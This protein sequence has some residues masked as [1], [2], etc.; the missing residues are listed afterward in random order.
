MPFWLEALLPCCLAAPS[1]LLCCQL[2]RLYLW[3]PPASQARPVAT[4]LLLQ[5]PTAHCY[6]S[7]AVLL[8]LS[9]RSDSQFVSF[10]PKR[11]VNLR[12]VSFTVHPPVPELCCVMLC[13]AVLRHAQNIVKCYGG[14][15]EPP[16]SFIVSLRGVQGPL[17]IART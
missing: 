1:L 9:A 13:H 5:P 4:P 12:E 17:R 7:A 10:T 14:N 15:L 2:L 16:S 3:W 6:V 8:C 11:F